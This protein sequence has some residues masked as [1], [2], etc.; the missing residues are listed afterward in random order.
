MAFIREKITLNEDFNAWW[1]L[2]KYRKKDIESRELF[3][4]VKVKQRH[5]SN[6]G[7]PGSD[8]DVMYWV[9]LHNGYAVGFREH[10]GP[11]GTRR[12]KFCEFPYAKLEEITR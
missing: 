8:K 9:E 12:A 6:Y 10:R 2:P 4:D 11:S 1:R 5:G 3:G 7:W